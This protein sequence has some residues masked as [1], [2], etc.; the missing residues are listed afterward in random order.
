MPKNYTEA[1]VWFRKSA[2][3]DDPVAQ[4]GLGVCYYWGYGVPKDGK[5]ALRWWTMSAEQGYA[6]AQYSIGRY[7]EKIMIM[8]KR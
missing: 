6:D 3:Q 5:E 2:E 4:F 7:L 8:Y 1:V